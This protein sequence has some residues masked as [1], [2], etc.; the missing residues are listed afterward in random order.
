MYVYRFPII[1]LGSLYIDPNYEAPVGVSS[2]I[3]FEGARVLNISDEDILEE[4]NNS[5]DG[6][7][8]INGVAIGLSSSFAVAI[9]TVGTVIGVLLCRMVYR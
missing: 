4:W 1:L 7:K 3:G 2:T 9:I 5:G 8:G 6:K